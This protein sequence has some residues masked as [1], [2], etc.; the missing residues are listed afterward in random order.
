MPREAPSWAR[1][2]AASYKVALSNLTPEESAERD[3]E[4]ARVKHNQKKRLETARFISKRAHEG[5]SPEEIASALGITARCLFRKTS[6]WGFD[7]RQRAG[8]RRLFV[9]V[10]ESRVPALEVLASDMGLTRAAA[11]EAILDA[12]LEEGAHVARRVL[13]VKSQIRVAA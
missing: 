12:A 6:R 10:S 5:D 3:A 7:L 1:K 11:L 13:K 2:L 9:W 4:R 8:F